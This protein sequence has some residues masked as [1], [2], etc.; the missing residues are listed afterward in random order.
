M[1]HLIKQISK[2]FKS[3]GTS[4]TGKDKNNGSSTPISSNVEIPLPRYLKQYGNIVLIA[5]V[6][7]FQL[8]DIPKL[9]A[10]GYKR[11]TEIDK[12]H[13]Q[14][15]KQEGQQQV[16][17]AETGISEA[18]KMIQEGIEGIQALR[19]KWRAI[20]K[21]KGYTDSAINSWLDKHF[22]LPNDN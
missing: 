21:E 1:L 22:P 6:L 18:E 20:L 8:S 4:K 7:G 11:K 19:N 10:D 14:N 3:N 9:F 2:A 15:L 13:F 12:S 17:E 5:L 16:K